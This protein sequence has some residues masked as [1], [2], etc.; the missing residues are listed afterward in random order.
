MKRQREEPKG[1]LALKPLRRPFCPVPPSS[2][3]PL[4]W[5]SPPSPLP[6][7]L[8]L[9]LLPP[10]GRW[11]RPIFV[12]GGAV[13]STEPGVRGPRVPEPP[14]GCRRRGKKDSAPWRVKAQS[15]ALINAS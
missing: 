13:G 15:G 11:W 12:A 2:R 7:G 8:L 4:P 1:S 3:R 9:L 14:Q 5:A 10:G 6:G